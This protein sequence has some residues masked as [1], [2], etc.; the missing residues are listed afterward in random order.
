M[1]M[2]MFTVPETKATKV[3]LGNNTAWSP[4]MICGLE[5]Q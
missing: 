4:I 1:A 3:E 5:T 2:A